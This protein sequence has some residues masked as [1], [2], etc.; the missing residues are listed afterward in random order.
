MK[1]V[2][3]ALLWIG[4]ALSLPFVLLFGASIM[5]MTTEGF[6]SQYINSAL[7]GIFCA[8]FSVAVGYLLRQMLLERID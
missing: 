6:Q 1:L 2:A 7:L 4:V 8:A 5:R 3:S